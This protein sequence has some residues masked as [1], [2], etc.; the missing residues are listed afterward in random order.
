VEF[1]ER[2]GALA[3][4]LV[5]VSPAWNVTL[6]HYRRTGASLWQRVRAS[7]SVH[8][9][10]RAVPAGVGPQGARVGWGLLQVSLTHKVVCVSPGLAG[11]GV[12]CTCVFGAMQADDLFEILPAPRMSCF[13]W[14]A[15]LQEL[16]ETLIS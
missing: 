12:L 15:A 7:A 4:F 10:G 8:C 9:G 1:P 11:R 5:V 2:A 6:F 16:K 13:F 14:H 3:R